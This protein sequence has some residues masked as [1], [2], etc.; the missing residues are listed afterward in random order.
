MSQH[1]T[2]LEAVSRNHG[3]PN[4]PDRLLS[5][6]KKEGL[7]EFHAWPAGHWQITAKG[8]DYMANEVNFD[9]EDAKRY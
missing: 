6:A 5:A 2:A 9:A 3:V 7:I 1:R 8:C 4:C